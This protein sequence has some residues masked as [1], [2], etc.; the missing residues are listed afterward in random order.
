M[1]AMLAGLLLVTNC[2]FSAG[3]S[4][5]LVISPDAIDLRGSQRLQY[6]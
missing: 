1:S 3:A 2:T 4:G 6:R 5:F